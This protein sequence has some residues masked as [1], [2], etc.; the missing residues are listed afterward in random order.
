MANDDNLNIE[1]MPEDLDYSFY[2]YMLERNES[3]F[4]A[5]AIGLSPIKKYLPGTKF[6]MVETN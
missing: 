5:E 4:D 1:V 3:S 6:N 2:D